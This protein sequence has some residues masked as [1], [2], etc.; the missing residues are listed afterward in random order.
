M[1]LASPRLLTVAVLVP[2]A[3][4]LVLAAPVVTRSAPAPHPVAPHIQNLP[5][6]GRS[7]AALAAHRQAVLAGGIADSDVLA[8]TDELRPGRSPR[9][10]PGGPPAA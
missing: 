6:S 3:V 1:R 10:G 7:G 4:P 2:A 5:V 8:V 9:S